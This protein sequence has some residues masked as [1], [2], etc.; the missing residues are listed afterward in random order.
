MSKPKVSSRQVA[1]QPASTLLK[2]IMSSQERSEGHPIPIQT[3]GVTE[4][5]DTKYSID[6]ASAPM[7]Q[8][9]YAAEMCSMTFNDFDA[10]IVFAQSCLV[11]DGLDSALVIRMSPQALIELA[12]SFAGFS[13]KIALLK[14]QLGFKEDPLVVIDKRPHN[15]ATAVANICSVAIAGHESCLDFYHASAF[16]MGKSR[17]NSSLDIEPVVRVDMRTSQFA[18]LVDKVNEVAMTLNDLKKGGK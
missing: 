16:A 3:L 7:P 15:M 9:R 10:K 12:E 11:P 6:V 2:S 14:T 8:R 5:G 4:S 18:S 13:E 17:T 1:K